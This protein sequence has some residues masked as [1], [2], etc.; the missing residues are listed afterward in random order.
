MITQIAFPLFAL[1]SRIL[2]MIHFYR[3]KINGILLWHVFASLPKWAVTCSNLAVINT[4][5]IV[6]IVPH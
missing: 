1:F 2:Y 4:A 3:P 5:L 6:Y